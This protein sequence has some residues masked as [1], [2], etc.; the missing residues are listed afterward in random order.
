MNSILFSLYGIDFRL[1]LIPQKYQGEK[2]LLMKMILFWLYYKIYI[3]IY[4][5]IYI[6]KINLKFIYFKII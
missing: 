6:I 4:I 1:C 5:Y 3:Y 2:K